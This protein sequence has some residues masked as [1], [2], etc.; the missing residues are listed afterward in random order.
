MKKSFNK[1]IASKGLYEM[2]QYSTAV[3]TCYYAMFLTAKA[4]IESPTKLFFD[5][6]KV[7]LKNNN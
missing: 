6:I 2:E 5:R 1:L 7:L 4:E 3:C